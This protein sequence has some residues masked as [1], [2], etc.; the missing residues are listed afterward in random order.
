MS[1][2]R[3]GLPPGYAVPDLRQPVMQRLDHLWIVL[4]TFGITFSPASDLGTR[5]RP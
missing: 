2:V 4:P 3:A 5:C 1:P